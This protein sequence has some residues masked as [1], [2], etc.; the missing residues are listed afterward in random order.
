M[1]VVSPDGEVDSS[2][3]LRTTE[4]VAHSLRFCLPVAGP[5]LTMRLPVFSASSTV[6]RVGA[7]QLFQRCFKPSC[8]SQGSLPRRCRYTSMISRLCSYADQKDS[9]G[10]SAGPA[11]YF[12]GF[13]LDYCG[14][15]EWRDGRAIR[16]FPLCVRL[17]TSRGDQLQL[18]HRRSLGQLPLPSPLILAR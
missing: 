12:A 6:M 10:H 7:A 13:A 18:D 11:A 16:R 4:F 15:V 17:L 3:M 1:V 9:D 2:R 8:G 5:G 14:G